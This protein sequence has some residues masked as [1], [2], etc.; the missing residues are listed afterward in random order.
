MSDAK[1]LLKKLFLLI[2]YF[3]VVV[4]KLGHVKGFVRRF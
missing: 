1:K 3:S 4:V 2:F